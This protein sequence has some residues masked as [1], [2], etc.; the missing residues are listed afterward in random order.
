MYRKYLRMARTEAGALSFRPAACLFILPDVDQQGSRL[1]FAQS[2]Q[3]FPPSA[4]HQSKKSFLWKSRIWPQ[5][6]LC[7]LNWTCPFCLCAFS[8]LSSPLPSPFQRLNWCHLYKLFLWSFQSASLPLASFSWCVLY[9]C[10][11]RQSHLFPGVC[12][13]IGLSDA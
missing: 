6:P 5:S 1:L 12:R 3:W 7:Q 8:D 4:L 2:L 11:D 13:G 10:R 9:K